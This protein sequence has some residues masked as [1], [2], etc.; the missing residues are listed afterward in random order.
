M[1]RIWKEAVVAESIH[2]PNICLEGLMK[3]R[4]RFSQ[5]FDVPEE[6]G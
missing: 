5:Y 2:Y 6:P 1:E 4:R 3:A